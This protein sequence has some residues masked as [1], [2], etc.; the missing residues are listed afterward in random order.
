MAEIKTH[1]GKDTF[2]IDY[3]IYYPFHVITIY[4]IFLFLRIN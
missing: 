1:S 2:D 3:V 4:R